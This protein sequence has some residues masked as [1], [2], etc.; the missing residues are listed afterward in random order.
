M[1]RGL[2]VAGDK[3]GCRAA[4]YTQGTAGC[5]T[6]RAAVADGWDGL[7]GQLLADSIVLCTM[8]AYTLPLIAKGVDN[9]VTALLS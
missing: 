9:Q 2:S 6:L 5:T 3:S 7:C 4:S 8:S 1:L